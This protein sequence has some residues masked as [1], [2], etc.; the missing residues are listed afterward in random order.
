M[1]M[2]PEQIRSL[3]LSLNKT[4]TEF[5][6]LLDCHLRTVQL[7]EKGESNPN[8]RTLM[9]LMDIKQEND[10]DKNVANIVAES[11][12]DYLSMSP[13][14]IIDYISTNED[15]F[16]PLIEWEKLM[17]LYSL[18]LDNVKLQDELANLKQKLNGLPG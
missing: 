16:F 7:Y 10:Q 12:E 18:Y 1:S 5:A 6:E 4:Q 15:D 14:S 13:K 17:R 8:G 9:K 2:T 11:N 3:R